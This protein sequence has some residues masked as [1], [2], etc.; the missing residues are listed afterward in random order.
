[1]AMARRIANSRF[2]RVSHLR[3]PKLVIWIF[4]IRDR[5]SLVSKGSIAIIS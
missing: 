1:M 3:K 4:S 2:P 5:T